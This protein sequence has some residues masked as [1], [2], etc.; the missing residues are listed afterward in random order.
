MTTQ[1]ETLFPRPLSGVAVTDLPSALVPGRTPLVGRHVQ[2]EPLNPALHAE[3]LYEASHLTE[4]GR[5]IWTYLPDGPWPDL[6]AYTSQLRRLSG[7][8]DRVFHIIRAGA[9][10]SVSGQASFMDIDAGNGVIEIGYIWFAP[11][12]QRT[13]AATEAL[14][15]MLD[16]AMTALRYRR[17]QWR[18]NAL[19]AKSRGAARR[20]G[21]RFEGIFH[22]HLIYKGLN[23]DT[24]WYSILDDEWPE[25]RAILEEWLDDAN[26]DAQGQA[27]R[28]LTVMMQDRTPST[29]AR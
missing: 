27:R 13:R 11:S 25:V 1:N 14:Y 19:N 10:G 29:R 22:N 20:L 9:E 16:H 28:S 2:L 12:L 5:A 3:A 17:M 26:F 21:F 23:R 8:V 7:S 15:L 18:C 24:A 4:E 6:A